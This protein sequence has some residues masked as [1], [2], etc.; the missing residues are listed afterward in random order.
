[1]V[2]FD[3]QIVWER[4]NCLFFPLCNLGYLQLPWSSRE[5]A[6]REAMGGVHTHW[7]WSFLGG[8]L[9]NEWLEIGMEDLLI[10]TSFCPP[11]CSTGKDLLFLLCSSPLPSHVGAG[12]QTKCWA[13]NMLSELN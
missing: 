3:R 13:K 2:Y 12:M 9:C 4:V 7:I 8:I 11:K 10:H 1:M 5:V 6:C